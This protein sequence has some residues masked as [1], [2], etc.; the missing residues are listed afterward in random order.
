MPKGFD[1]KRRFCVFVWD[2][3]YDLAPGVAFDDLP[4]G[5]SEKPVFVCRTEEFDRL[6]S[7]LKENLSGGDFVLLKG[8]RGLALERLEQV[9]KK[10]GWKNE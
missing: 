7:E 5:K 6:E 2:A 10:E 1:L 4:E 8:S 3:D 9:L